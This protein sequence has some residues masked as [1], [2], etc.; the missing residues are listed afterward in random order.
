MANWVEPLGSTAKSQTQLSSQ[1]LWPPNI[2]DGPPTAK[3]NDNL[4][5]LIF[6]FN[7]VCTPANC[8][9]YYGTYSNI[10]ISKSEDFK[11]RRSSIFCHNPSEPTLT[12]LGD[13]QPTLKMPA[14]VGISIL[15]ERVARSSSC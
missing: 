10:R 3:K 1:G 12:L 15:I 7:V 14:P 6:V 5:L 4:A 11:N 13:A 8:C 9:L 2:F